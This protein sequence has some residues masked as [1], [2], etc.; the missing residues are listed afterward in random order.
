[1]NFTSDLKKELIKKN[2]TGD[3]A[4]AQLSAY[5]TVCGVFAEEENH[6]LAAKNDAP[7][8]K[9]VRFFL[10]S[11]TEFVAEY[12]TELFY[13]VFSD[14]LV[15]THA[16]KDRRSGR[17]R[18]VLEYPKS[19]SPVLRA[20]GLYD[21]KNGLCRGIPRAFFDRDELR[22]AYMRGVFLGGGSLILPSEDG[23]TG[24]HLECVFPSESYA[25]DEDVVSDDFC[26][27]A[28]ES[29]L[30][31]KSVRRG[32]EQ[33][34]YMKSKEAISDFLS[35]IGAENALRK[36]TAFC[37]KREHNNR[38]NRAA[39]CSSFNADK[40]ATAA[41]KQIMAIKKIIDGGAVDTLSAPLKECL[42]LRY[43]HPEMSLRELAETLNVSK[44]C[45]THR[46]RKIEEIAEKLS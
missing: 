14:R 9:E 16:A 37:E 17:S 21:E 45:L 10:V 44:S 41:V 18:L 42:E 40:T 24:Y 35:V 15:V 36:F 20:L 7:S 26:L 8:A 34:V 11:E 1:M 27:L 25:D 30:L 13:S 38:L 23:K 22:A 32:E 12:F 4:V 28:E 31:F 19:A 46:I 33:V 5:F 2:V 29:D 6:R 3:A 39:N 43:A